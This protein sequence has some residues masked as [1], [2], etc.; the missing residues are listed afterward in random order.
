M[1]YELDVTEINIGF[2]FL[3][4]LIELEKLIFMMS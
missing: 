1:S 3:G 2:F 4:I